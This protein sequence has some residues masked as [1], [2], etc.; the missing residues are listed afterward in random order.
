MNEEQI[1]EYERLPHARSYR[2]IDF[3][4]A[5][6]RTLESLPPQ[7]ILVVRGTKPYVNMRVKLEPL[8]YVRQPEYWGIEVVG[9][10]RGGIGLPVMS[11]TPSRF[12]WPAS[13]G[14]RA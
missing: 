7:Y 2:L 12:R 14:P 3:E 5:E 6:V 4:E 10:I 11:P 8:I 1:R 13:S 9:R